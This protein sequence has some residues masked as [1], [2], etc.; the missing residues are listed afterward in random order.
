VLQFVHDDL[1]ALRLID[2][3]RHETDTDPPRLSQTRL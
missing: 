2:N 1:H 3:R